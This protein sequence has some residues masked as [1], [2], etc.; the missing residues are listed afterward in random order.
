MGNTR[1]VIQFN[2]ALYINS[3]SE[4]RPKPVSRVLWLRPGNL[5]SAPAI[6][7]GFRSP[8]TSNDL[9]VPAPRR[10]KDE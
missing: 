3:K 10:N 9:P 8:G 5:I 7:P 1:Y 4:K 6:Y 2:I